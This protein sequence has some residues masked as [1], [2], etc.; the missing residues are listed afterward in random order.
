[1][2]NEV[3]HRDRHDGDHGITFEPVDARAAEMVE[4]L[5]SLRDEPDDESEE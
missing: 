1:M 3:D 2:A 5:F 4:W